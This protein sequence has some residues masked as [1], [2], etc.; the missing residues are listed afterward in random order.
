[1]NARIVTLTVVSLWVCTT[2]VFPQ[3]QTIE[4][5]WVGPGSAS[6]PHYTQK[7]RQD[8]I[9]RNFFFSWAQGYLSGVNSAVFY[10]AKNTNL[11]NR[12][13]EDQLDFIDRYCEQ[14]PSAFYVQAVLN[15]YDYMRSEQ[16]LGDWRPGPLKPH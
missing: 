5:L 12:S 4:G 11:A 13:I 2:P 10:S 9:M 6:C 14:H 7:V 15:L 16:G 3:G 8:Q 1:M